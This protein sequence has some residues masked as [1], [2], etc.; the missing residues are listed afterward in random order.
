LKA[1]PKTG[2]GTRGNHRKNKFSYNSNRFEAGIL[3]RRARLGLLEQQSEPIPS[4]RFVPR[5]LY[6]KTDLFDR[7]LALRGANAT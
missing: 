4:Q 5:H 2:R 1:P 6:R 7:L 3:L